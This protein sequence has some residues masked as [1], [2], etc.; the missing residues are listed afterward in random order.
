[1]K[2]DDIRKKTGLQKLEDIIKERKTNMDGTCPMNGR[3][4]NISPGYTV[5]VERIQDQDDQG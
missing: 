5:G 2:N 1:M 3:L 4:H